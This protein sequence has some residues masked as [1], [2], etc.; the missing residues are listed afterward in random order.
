MEFML[1]TAAAMLNCEQSQLHP[2]FVKY[3]GEIQ[4]MVFQVDGQITSRQIV[5]PAIVNWKLIT[6]QKAK[7]D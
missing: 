3:L 4:S 6:G 1:R 2:D 7:V 5:A